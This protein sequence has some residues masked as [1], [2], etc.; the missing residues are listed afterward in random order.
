M[1]FKLFSQIARISLL[2][3][4]LFIFTVG[5]KADT[6][7][8]RNVFQDAVYISPVI[9]TNRL[10]SG[11]G[12]QWKQE[13][14]E[15]EANKN[16]HFSVRYYDQKKWSQW[17]LLEADIDGFDEADKENPSAFLPMNTTDAFQYKIHAAIAKTD[18]KKIVKS[19]KFT[20]IDAH[21]GVASAKQNFVATRKKILAQNSSSFPSLLSNPGNIR[22]ISRAQWGADESLR[23]YKE[24]NLKPT[25]VKTESDFENKYAN[26]LKI[27]RTVDTDENGHK[28]TWPLKYPEKI[29]KIVI[30][31]TA[32]SK[33]LDDPLKAIRNIYFWH[34]VTRGWGDIGYNYL[35][36]QKGNI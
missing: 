4:F 26:E 9:K 23:L 14:E 30:H 33:D 15:P 27:V 10:F 8:R 13:N 18:I 11:L 25:L 22:I 24:T 1:N 12:V 5:V 31:H 21:E 3:A 16:V 35:I 20:Y 17:Y 32:S 19:L 36:D 29:S 6:E 34:A 2:L 28:L 7:W